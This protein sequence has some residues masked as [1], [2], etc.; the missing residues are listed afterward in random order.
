MMRS[1]RFSKRT[2]LLIGVPAIAVIVGLAVKF[3]S[4]SEVSPTPTSTPRREVKASYSVGDC[5][6]VTNNVVLRLG[7][8][9]TYP[10]N[11][12]IPVRLQPPIHILGIPRAGLTCSSPSQCNPRDQGWWW[13]VEII[14]PDNGDHDQG[15][16]WQGE[17]KACRS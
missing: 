13:P 7:P 4:G 12:N 3:P 10:P 1:S 9:I 6:R 15:W 17:T 16:L 2:I 8:G 5:V 11:T 14:W